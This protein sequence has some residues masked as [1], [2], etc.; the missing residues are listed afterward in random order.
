MY[1][2]TAF[3]VGGDDALMLYIYMYSISKMMETTSR[4][5]SSGESTQP[6]RHTLMY[7]T[8]SLLTCLEQVS[9]PLPITVQ[10][11]HEPI[12]QGPNSR[13]GTNSHEVAQIPSSA[14]RLDKPI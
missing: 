14:S 2:L 5:V 9:E 7:N 3:S 4:E 10:F 12:R 8:T 1:A 6:T 11:E 13:R